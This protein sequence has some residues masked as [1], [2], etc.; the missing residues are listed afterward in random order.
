MACGPE[1]VALAVS[2]VLHVVELGLLAWAVINSRIYRQQ[3]SAWM[4]N[5]LRALQ[6]DLK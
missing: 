1:D 2:L 3:Q 6:D 4:R 5:H